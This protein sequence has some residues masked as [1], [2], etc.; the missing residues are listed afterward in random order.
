MASAEHEVPPDFRDAVS[1]LLYQSQ[2]VE[3]L[4]RVYLSD[5]NEAAD[6]LLG[7]EGV[8]FKPRIKDFRKRTLGWLVERFAAHSDNDDLTG[9]LRSFVRHRNSAAHTAYAWAFVNREATESVAATLEKVR[10]HCIEG[11]ALVEAVTRETMKTYQL[12]AKYATPAPT[13]QP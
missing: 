7:G 3:W 6:T 11:R 13:K 1:E 8:R 9:R 2:M 4:L 10:A 5:I 12:K